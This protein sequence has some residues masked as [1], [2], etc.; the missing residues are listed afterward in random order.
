MIDLVP[1]PHFTIPFH[2]HDHG[3]NGTRVHVENQDTS[4]EIF[5]CVEA[6]V[7]YNIGYRVEKPRFGIHDQT[8]RQSG[9]DRLQLEADILRWESRADLLLESDP[10]RV[11][12]LV[13][14]VQVEVH[15]GPFAGRRGET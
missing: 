15:A 2:F 14:H 3:Q 1:I 5:S 13:S 8:F 9:V 4:E 11:D 7:R 12:E 6:T 10:Q